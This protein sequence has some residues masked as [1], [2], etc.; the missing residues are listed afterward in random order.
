MDSYNN[1]GDDDLDRGAHDPD[2]AGEA[3]FNPYRIGGAMTG[4]QMVQLAGLELQGVGV[5]R[6]L[7][8]GDGGV[9]GGDSQERRHR[10]MSMTIQQLVLERMRMQWD[11]QVITVGG[12]QM[13]N[14]E[15]QAARQAILDDPDTYTRWA[16]EQGL[17]EAGQEHD[18]EAFVERRMELD[19]IRRDNGGRFRSDQ[20]DLRREYEELDNHPFRHAE[21]QAVAHQHRSWLGLRRDAASHQTEALENDRHAPRSYAELQGRSFT[22]ASAASAIDGPSHGHVPPLTPTFAAGAAGEAVSLESEP[23][24]DRPAP[25]PVVAR[26]GFD[27]G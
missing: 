18:F 7:L 3:P 25:D 15:R 14:A 16:V 8:E 4:A 5:V 21:D 11:S 17:I 22:G 13:T 23:V 12:V 6:R 24:P 2:V 9:Q 1:N 19:D 20:G 26:S 27:I 10:D